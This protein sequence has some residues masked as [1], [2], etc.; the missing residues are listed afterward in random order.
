[1]TN[2][3][4]GLCIGIKAD[5]STEEGCI[6]LAEEIATRE[7]E[8]NVLINN[9]GAT[10]GD[11]FEDHPD[12]GF[13][14]LFD[15]KIIIRLLFLLR[16]KAWN[17]LYALNVKGVFYMTRALISLLD[18]GSRPDDPG[19][20][21][22]IGSIAGSDFLLKAYGFPCAYTARF[23]FFSRCASPSSPHLCLRCKQGCGS[24]S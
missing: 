11:A 19:R 8:V 3:G 15:L 22:N 9:S 5:L 21:I 16:S 10:W 2:I 6:G 7:N 14:L 20:I 12:K 18:K 23:F 24:P 1:M 17:K 13:F 4:P